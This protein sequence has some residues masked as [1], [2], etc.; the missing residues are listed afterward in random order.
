MSFWGAQVIVNLFGTIPVIGP[1]I[2]EWIR[3][4]YGI[5]DATLDRFFALHVAAVPLVILLFVMLHLVALHRT[6]SNNPDGIEIKERVGADGRPLDG[7]PFHPYYT[8]KDI[9]GVGVMLVLFAIVVFFV[10]SFGGLFLEAPNFGPANPMS[11]PEH[12]APVWYFT[13]YYALLRAVPDQRMGA[14]LM[15]LSVALFVFLPWLDR[16]PVKSM[17]Y[18][19]TLSKGALAIFAVSFSVLG[20]LGLQPAEGVYVILARIFACGYFGFF[21]LMPWYSRIDEVKPVPERVVF[22]EHS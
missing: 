18:R 7:I 14:L 4:D 1:G 9:V 22:H 5:A 8:V 13:P 2:V 10:P 15:A 19:G 20:Y 3:G 12:I 17:R 16:L 21:L 6:G 11:T